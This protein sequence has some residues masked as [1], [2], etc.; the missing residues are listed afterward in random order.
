MESLLYASAGQ[1]SGSGNPIL[2]FL[3]FLLIILV[4]YFLMIR[5]QAKKQKEKQ[6]MLQSLQPGDEV[7]T[8]GGIIGKI[9]GIKEKENI[10][11]LKISK[12]VK[13]QVSRSAIANKI[14]R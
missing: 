1:A 3:P 11:I 12:D 7:M 2:A 8:I 6:M 9:E 13:I 10:I 4:M 5:P 14:S